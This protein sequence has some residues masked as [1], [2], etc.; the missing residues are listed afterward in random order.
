[1]REGRIIDIFDE[2]SFLSV[3][4]KCFEKHRFRPK[5]GRQ[6]IE[7]FGFAP[8]EEIISLRIVIHELNNECLFG[9]RLI[10]FVK[11]VGCV[12][13]SVFV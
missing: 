12:G 4:I 13:F 1:M 5:I 10:F 9:C 11:K 3:Q 8:A 7:F 6:L 2:P